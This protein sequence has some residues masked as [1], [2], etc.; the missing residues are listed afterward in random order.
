MSINAVLNG[1]S[2]KNILGTIESGIGYN[3]GKLH[4]SINNLLTD[5][6][7]VISDAGSKTIDSGLAIEQKIVN[8]G[9]QNIG[10]FAYNLSKGISQGTSEGV[11][12]GSGLEGWTLPILLGVGVIATIVALKI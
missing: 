2:P 9:S 3:Y 4:G 8:A 5:A 1:V 12:V 10:N 11:S 6:K 7:N